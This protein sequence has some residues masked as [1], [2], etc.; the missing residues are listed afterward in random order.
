VALQVQEEIKE[1]VNGVDVVI[2]GNH[3]GDGVILRN[4][5]GVGVIL[6]NQGEGLER[7]DGKIIIR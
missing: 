5:G 1:E 7:G 6:G 2:P 4:Q 3:G